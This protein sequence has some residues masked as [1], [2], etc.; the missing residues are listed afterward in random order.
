MA[1]TFSI[2]FRKERF[3]SEGKP[4]TPAMRH[5]PSENFHASG[6][7]VDLEKSRAVPVLRFPEPS[8]LVNKIEKQPVVYDLLRISS[9]DSARSAYLDSGFDQ[10]TRSESEKSFVSI[11]YQ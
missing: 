6:H 2:F 8:I 3:G 1:T 10:S 9:Y 5:Q 7:D 4:S 11:C